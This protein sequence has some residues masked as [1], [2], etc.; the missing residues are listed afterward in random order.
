MNTLLL[1]AL[2]M[3]ASFL[4]SACAKTNDEARSSEPPPKAEQPVVPNNPLLPLMSPTPTATP[5]K[6]SG[7]PPSPAEIKDTLARVFDKS[8]TADESRNPAF[9]VGDFN[10][11]GSDDLAVAVTVSE[12]SLREINNELANWTLEDPQNVT[13]PKPGSTTPPPPKPARAEKGDSL[14]AIIHGVGPEGWRSAD[15][16]QTFLLKNGA[17]ANILTQSHEAVRHS[18]QKLPPIRG[19]VINETIGSK[20]G[21]L[22][23]NGAKYAWYSP[24]PN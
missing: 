20:A 8:A 4:I 3:S 24:A 7:P 6:K 21:F 17:G 15:A 23:W 1:S 22:F 12:N 2:L 13:S 10:G 14:L 9:A 18:K 5:A 16:R 19:D 11:D